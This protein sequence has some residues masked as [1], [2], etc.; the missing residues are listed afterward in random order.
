MS[1]LRRDLA[2]CTF[3][4]SSDFT[5]P[6]RTT[7]IL[8]FNGYV[9]E[10]GKTYA[11]YTVFSFTTGETSAMTSTIGNLETGKTY[12]TTVDGL[13]SGV[14]SEVISGFVTGYTATTITID[15]ETFKVAS[16][17]KAVSHDSSSPPQSKPSPTHTEPCSC[18]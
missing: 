6:P 15:G 17:V 14:E 9:Y 7:Y 12:K 2:S 11:E 1:R 18:S 16:D 5:T 8:K 3:R 13:I 4:G 10:N